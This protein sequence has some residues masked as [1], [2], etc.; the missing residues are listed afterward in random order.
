MKQRFP[1]VVVSPERG[2]SGADV[3]HDGT[4]FRTFAIAASIDNFAYAFAS[5]VPDYLHVVADHNAARGEPVRA[6][7]ARSVRR[8]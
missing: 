1:S 6:F 3:N 8:R 2:L 4:D 7:I 5:T